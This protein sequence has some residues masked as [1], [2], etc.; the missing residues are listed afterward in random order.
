[1]QVK[2]QQLELDMEQWTGSKLGKKCNKPVYCHSA[3]LTSMHS[4]M[5]YFKLE[6]RLPELISTTSDRY[7]V[8]TTLMAE[9]EEAQKSLLMR[10]KEESD[11]AGLNLTLKH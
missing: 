10:V 3:Y 11:K 1:M 2:K 6:S 4:I 5:Q 7:A 9:S 8:E